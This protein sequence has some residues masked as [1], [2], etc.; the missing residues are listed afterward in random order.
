MV[1]SQVSYSFR[2]DLF[3]YDGFF[4]YT[5][6]EAPGEWTHIVVN[7]I[8]PGDTT[9]RGIYVYYNG[10]L[11]GDDTSKGS[12]SFTAGNGRVVVGRHLPN[13]D[14]EYAGV[15]VDELLLFNNNLN[16]DKCKLLRQIGHKP[17]QHLLVLPS[18]Q[19]A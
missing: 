14:D 5:H 15:E 16:E 7:Y 19:S 4:G 12:A 10:G 2:H 6:N 13:E 9:T 18:V 11:E 8:G 3:L 17:S 1:C